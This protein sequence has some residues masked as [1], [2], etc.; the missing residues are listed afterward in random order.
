MMWRRYVFAQ[1]FGVVGFALFEP[2]SARLS[3]ITATPASC[4]MS[5]L[6]SRLLSCVG[7]EGAISSALAPGL[8]PANSNVLAT[9]AGSALTTKTQTAS[10]QHPHH[11]RATC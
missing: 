3:G 4:N 7:W 5:R 8:T 11:D 6:C 2:F 9:R 10:K 1:F